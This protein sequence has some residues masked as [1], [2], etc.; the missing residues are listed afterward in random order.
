MKK[1]I[2]LAVIS[3]T[4]GMNAVA[5]EKTKK[6]ETKTLSV[7]AEENFKTNTVSLIS[8][9][10]SYVNL[11]PTMKNDFI[12]LI[13]MRKDAM[14]NV[15]SLEDKKAVFT[16]YTTKMVSGLNDEQRKILEL[17]HPDFYKKLTEYQADSK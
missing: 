4:V 6:T 13:Y 7:N 14:A 1:I 8:E 16:K 15:T 10:D 17:K 11:D 5:Q 12:N 9:L 3:L 2:L